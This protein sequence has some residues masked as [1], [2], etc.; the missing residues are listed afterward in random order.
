MKLTVILSSCVGGI[1]LF[2]WKQGNTWFKSILKRSLSEGSF[3]LELL[4]YILNSVDK[5]ICFIPKYV[6]LNRPLS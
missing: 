2:Q 1:D 4:K 3:F 5:D 6:M